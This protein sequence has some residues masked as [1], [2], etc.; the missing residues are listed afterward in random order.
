MI[1]SIRQAL[2]VTRREVRDQLRDWRVIFPILT[3]TFFFPFLMNFTARQILDFV[4]RYGANIIGERMVPFLLMVVGFFPISVSLVI[5]LESFVGEK[6]RG[7]IEP[8]LNTP[9]ENWQL[10]LGKLLSSII[11]SLISSYFGMAV[12][13]IGLQIKGIPLPDF[14]TLFQ[15]VA[16]TSV[17][18][19]MMV[20]GA[21]VVSTQATS[22]RAANLLA[23]FI[24]IPAALLIQGE[25]V[26]MFWGNSSTLWWV[27]FGVFVLS[28]L[29]V[30][31][32]LAH[33][34]REE[35][36]GREI[37]ALNLQW[38]LKHFWTSFK[39]EAISVINWY[40]VALRPALRILS[41]PAFLVT[42][43][44]VVSFFIGY[45]QIDRFSISLQDLSIDDV[46]TRLID[47]L[48]VWK[49]VPLLPI[50][51]VWWQNVRVMLLAL[52]LGIISL[53]ILGVAPLIATVGI[54]GYLL[55]ILQSS[56][57]PVL[58]FAL[59]VLPHG[60]LEIPA[61]ILATASVLR[62]GALMA[63]PVTGK[64]VGEV[65]IG[66]LAEWARIMV[67]VV[68]PF[69]FVAAAIEIWITPRIV[70]WFAYY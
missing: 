19:V 34:H 40:T 70:I 33:F 4:S 32:G 11:P 14:N 18:A 62:L 7:S 60:L 3:L 12:Y 56:G 21:V 39:G 55:A 66:G 37:D 59:F 23:S 41:L 9:L 28:V 65:F 27:V 42:V 54:A 58:T 17:Q 61:A 49:D 26:V 48:N 69:L 16:L 51:S 46:N 43:I 68:I 63:T 36:L 53:G 29:L 38:G 25:S 15:I 52:L 8:L 10:Y 20:A 30:R 57:L 24:I 6:E 2:I 31:V 1:N 64:T 13:L 45:A 35:L 67:G 22:V 47:M 50:V 44:V 5:A